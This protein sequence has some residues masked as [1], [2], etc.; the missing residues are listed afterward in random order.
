MPTRR[1][2]KAR[3]VM[4]A[5]VETL[6][7]DDTIHMALQLFEDSGISG[8]PVVG[9]DG[10][11]LG[12]L[13]LADVS[14]PEHEKDGLLETRSDDE[15][16]EPVGEERTDE[17][18]PAEAFYVKDD[19]SA[20][21]LGP[22]LVGDWM[23]SGVI[24]VARDASLEKVCETMVQNRVHRVCVVEKGVLVGLITSFDVVRHVARGRTRR[25]RHA[26]RAVRR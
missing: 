22:K 1:E 6:T 26:R 11:L 10:G 5:E 7:P 12:M 20:G 24:T 3:D 9:K 2:T 21:L 17:L 4:R 18:D 14:R 25:A 16:A 15:L 13:T 8:A 19:Y 23:T